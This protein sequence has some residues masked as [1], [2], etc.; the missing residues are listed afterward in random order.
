MPLLVTTASLDLYTAQSL[1]LASTRGVLLRDVEYGG[2][3]SRG[4]LRV[5]D[6]ILTFNGVPIDQPTDLQRELDRVSAG[7]N[8]TAI[9]WRDS[10]RVP[11]ALRF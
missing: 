1:N 7:A 8:V 4:G 3:G 11:V 6:T 9:V 5:G 2:A 10:R